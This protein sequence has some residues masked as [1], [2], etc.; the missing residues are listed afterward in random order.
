M[1][2]PVLLDGDRSA[3]DVE[4]IETCL[5]SI[6]KE[7]IAEAKKIDAA[8]ADLLTQIKQLI[9]RGGKRLRPQLVLKAYQAYSGTNRQAIVRVAA[10]QELFHAF[11]LI[12]DDVIDRDQTRWGG[13]NI[14]GH[15]TKEFSRQLNNPGEAR[16][17]GDA[18]AILAGDV[19]FN[20]SNEV[21]TTSDFPPGRVL[22]ALKLV[23][24]TMF[25]MTGGEVVDTGLPIF[26]PDHTV[27]DDDQL[28][29]LSDIKT[30]SYSFRTPLKLGALL[31]GAKTDQCKQLD[32]FG[33]SIGIAFQIRDD[34]LGIFGD[35]RR[36][37]KPVLSDIQEN[38]R[39][40][41][42][43]YGL[44]FANQRQ[45]KQ[46]K[47]ILGNSAATLQDLK[48][49]RTILR[50][51]GALAE[52]ETIMRH[53]CQQAHFTLMKANFPA[54]LTAYLADLPPLLLDDIA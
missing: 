8:Y 32:D 24:Q 19:C 34:I 53:H 28:I 39:T 50:N 48:T 47:T 33:R 7:K 9:G 22:K 46:L 40:I 20:L 23:Q 25:T 42:L 3:A 4:A 43:A 6:L 26:Y 1:P 44:R 49:V 30:A 35:E 41:L 31:A 11:A 10:S 17:Y 13:P 2:Q 15:Y 37:G 21:L 29:K 5:E 14:S 12:H 45:L 16:H 18:W 36:L 52:T 54:E 27:P 51:N 38:K